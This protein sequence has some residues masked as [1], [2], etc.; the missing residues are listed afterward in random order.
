MEHGPRGL[1]FVRAGLW[2]WT[3]ITNGLFRPWAECCFNT[4]PPAGPSEIFFFRP[5]FPAFSSLGPSGE[6]AT[7]EAQSERPPVRSSSGASPPTS[8]RQV[9]PP[10]IPHTVTHPEKARRLAGVGERTLPR[11]SYASCGRINHTHAR[12]HRRGAW[13]VQ[14]QITRPGRRRGR[15]APREEP[16]RVHSE[17][18]R[19]LGPAGTAS[20]WLLQSSLPHPAVQARKEESESAEAAAC[21]CR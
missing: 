5:F 14:V 13:V 18:F 7:T 2:W 21:S 15:G 20:G 4:S 1:I 8:I 17:P 6:S 10:S 19:C 12:T 9:C 16:T 11:P 3:Q